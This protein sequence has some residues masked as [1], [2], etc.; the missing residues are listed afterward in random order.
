VVLMYGE[1]SKELSGYEPERDIP[2]RFT[3]IRPGEKLFEELILDCE[4][5]EKTGHEKI[6]S[7]QSGQINQIRLHTD[8]ARLRS[9]VS[10]RH[11]EQEAKRCLFDAISSA[12]PEENAASRSNTVS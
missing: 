7:L 2:I 4:T 9:F 1:H 6:F 5:V 8:L 10:G 11:E 3:G 12:M